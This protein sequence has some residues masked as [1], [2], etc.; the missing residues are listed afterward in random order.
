MC[1]QNMFCFANCDEIFT[2][3]TNYVIT[4]TFEKIRYNAMTKCLLPGSTAE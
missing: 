1:R 4:P 2:F 3:P